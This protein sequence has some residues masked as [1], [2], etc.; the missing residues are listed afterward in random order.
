MKKIAVCVRP[1]ADG[2][3]S[4]F[5]MSAYELALNIPDAEISL[6]C[7]ASEKA[8]D[9]LLMLS[10]LGAANVY[11]LSDKAYVGSD[12]LATAYTLAGAMRQIAPDIICCGRKT[13]IGDTAQIPPMLAEYLGFDYHSD[14][15]RISENDG[16]LTAETLSGQTKIDT[17]CVISCEKALTLRRPR[18][19][20]RLGRLTVLSAQD[21]GID[22]SKTGLV[23][24]PTRVIESHENTSG[25]RKCKFMELSDFNKIVTRCLTAERTSTVET[26][27]RTANLENV[28]CVG[29][30]AAELA[31]RITETPEIID[32]RLT[33]DE[34]CA[35]IKVKPPNAVLFP[36]DSSGRET[37]ARVAV[38]MGL[39]LCA[40]CTD[41]ATDG[42]ELYMIRP[43]LSGSVIAKIK[44]LSRPALCT[45]RVK[46]KQSG[47]LIVSAGFGAK[48]ELEFLQK[49]AAD[50]G[51]EFASSRKMVDNG[52]T[53][54]ET[55]VGLTGKTVVPA[56]YIAV[57]ISG[58]V[59]HIVGMD[60]SG[61]VIAVNPDKNAPIFEY[62][63]YG[64]IATAEDMKR[65]VR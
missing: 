7:M 64:F 48:N 32:S 5:E 10:R 53:S 57:G 9:M 27:P 42:N 35:L 38:K 36:A 51:A 11:L 43:A 58:A 22:C 56:L 30:A 8:K 61:T 59:H 2:E 62:A 39:G 63:D 34:I 15:L 14:V 17:K 24:S 50:I 1:G 16:I 20:S 46:G 6:V 23:G 19:G 18:I 45:V 33:A 40:D 25:K 3:I 37:A 28:L 60:K 55:Q 47:D 29:E 54:Y 41:L 26:T 4:P 21:I 12:T 31:A 44:S 52:I 65:T 13:M 49:Y